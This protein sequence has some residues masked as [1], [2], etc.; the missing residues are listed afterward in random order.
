MNGTPTKPANGYQHEGLTRFLLAVS[1]L[2]VAPSV[3]LTYGVLRPVT[4]DWLLP[5]CLGCVLVTFICAAN[6]TIAM[7]RK[8]RPFPLLPRRLSKVILPLVI[9]GAGLSAVSLLI[10]ALNGLMA[11]DRPALFYALFSLV[12]MW[13][14]VTLALAGSDPRHADV[15]FRKLRLSTPTY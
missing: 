4:A 5:F 7:V 8:R 11:G 1:Y 6:G 14:M 13:P 3:M 9:V 12:L 2:A 10:A 15:W